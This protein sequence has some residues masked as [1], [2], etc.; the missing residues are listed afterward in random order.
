MPC[1]SRRCSVVVMGLSL[2]LKFS[3]YQDVSRAPGPQK[4]LSSSCLP[5]FCF[6]C[7][8]VA[9]GGVERGWAVGVH[10][11]WCECGGQRSTCGGFPNYMGSRHLTQAARPR[12]GS[13]HTLAIESSWLIHFVLE[14]ESCEVPTS[15]HNPPASV[16]Q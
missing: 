13:K 2:S 15:F 12:L 9:G 10:V 14:T 8:C 1:L 16:S 3:V 6:L 4:V 11:P 7:V 5:A